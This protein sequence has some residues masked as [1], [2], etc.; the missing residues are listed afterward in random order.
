MCS[1]TPCS[2]KKR[3]TGKWLPAWIT[4]TIIILLIVNCMP[5]RM[6]RPRVK[7][8]LSKPPLEGI[9][10][11]YLDISDA[12]GAEIIRKGC[13]ILEEK[14]FLELVENRGDADWLIIWKETSA[15]HM[16][17]FCK[18]IWGKQVVD[19]YEKI[20]W[21][22]KAYWWSGFNNEV[23]FMFLETGW[24]IK[25]NKVKIVTEVK[26]KDET[27]ILASKTDEENAQG[28]T[29]FIMDVFT[30]VIDKEKPSLYVG[31]EFKHQTLLRTPISVIQ[32][33]FEARDNLGMRKV[34]FLSNNDIVK[35]FSPSHPTQVLKGIA[36]I[37]LV[38]GENQIKIIA[39]DWCN[40][41]ISKTLT[42]IRTKREGKIPEGI[43]L[44]RLVVDAYPL[45]FDDVIIGGKREGIKV[46]VANKGEGTAYNVIVNLEGDEFLLS[47][48]GKFKKIGDIKPGEEREV[49]FS[50]LMPTVFKK[51]EANIKVFV[52]EERGYSP[53]R[54]PSFV[55]T[56]VP[57]EIEEEIVKTVEDV[58]HNVPQGELKREKGYALIIG[59]S[60]YLGEIPSPM[61]ARNDAEAVVKYVRK[62]FGIENIKTL[63]DDSATSGRIKGN[64]L[65]WLSKKKGFKVIYFAGHGVPDPENPREGDVYILP[66]DGD[67]ELKSTLISIEHIVDM[68]Y[69]EGDTVVFI[70]DACFSG[71]EGRTIRL[72]QR[73]LFVA[74]IKLTDA[75]IFAAAEG[76]QPSKE[77]KQAKHGYFTYYLLLGLKGKADKNHDGWITSMELYDFV[78]EKVIEATDGRQVPV[79]KPQKEI[80][81]GKIK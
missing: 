14:G 23:T 31:G 12:Y 59:I 13:E 65:D 34:V 66:Y 47:L 44:P 35:T 76:N 37:P 62:V 80:K 28:V 18:V 50:A 11:V 6:P 42:I 60:K 67:P 81:L 51:R 10:K 15:E 5:H 7:G 19:Y 40:Q 36:T 39:Y 79:L 24:F 30:N 29:E 52:T 3:V 70:I 55:F 73:P 27:E 20:S 54:K 17:D 75:I 63:F 49:T 1:E 56:L 72:A 16:G 46:K 26:N 21:P 9:P 74:K 53:T 57:A 38:L 8:M 71:G 45:D 25:F 69:N 61:Y 68:C 41:Q 22:E 78:K 33:P 2:K 48:W 43:L 58:D 64:L 32:I 4:L 77:F